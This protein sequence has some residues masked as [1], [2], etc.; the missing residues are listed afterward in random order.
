MF[1]A[2]FNYHVPNR[3]TRVPNRV[4]GTFGKKVLG[5]AGL[6]T[7]RLYPIHKTRYFNIEKYIRSVRKLRLVSGFESM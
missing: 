6:R 3:A 1:S 5:V 7:M 4:V 2:V